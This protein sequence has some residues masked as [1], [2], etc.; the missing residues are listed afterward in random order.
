MHATTARQRPQPSDVKPRN[1]QA[2]EL[3]RQA[4]EQVERY[5]RNSRCGPRHVS[6]ILLVVLAGLERRRQERA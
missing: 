3:A 2:D 4:R 5:R 1:R 6:E